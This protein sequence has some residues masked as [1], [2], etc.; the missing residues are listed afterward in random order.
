M[1]LIHLLF[2]LH[3][4]LGEFGLVLFF[5]SDY[6][7]DAVLEFG[8]FELQFPAQGFKSVQMTDFVFL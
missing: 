1:E 4:N 6:L 2:V 7:L 3:L 5:P 8:I